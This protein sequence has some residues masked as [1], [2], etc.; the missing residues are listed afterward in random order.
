MDVV[1]PK[2]D[3]EVSN[4]IVVEL[5]EESVVG[6]FSEAIEIPVVE[7]S[8]ATE[9]GGVGRIRLPGMFFVVSSFFDPF[10]LSLVLSCFSFF[11]REE[12]GD[13]DEELELDLD[14]D[15]FLFLRFFRSRPREEERDEEGEREYF[16]FLPTIFTFV[17]I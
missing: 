7:E 4:G 6:T 10:C 1:S 11:F 12:E 2:V 3:D 16:F 5:C 15:F 14:L 13:R 9:L 8:D 17:S